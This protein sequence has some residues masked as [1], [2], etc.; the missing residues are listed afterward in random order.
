M[1]TKIVASAEPPYTTRTFTG[2][3]INAFTSPQSRAMVGCMDVANKPLINP[4]VG[5]VEVTSWSLPIEKFI[6]TSIYG[7]HGPAFEA[8]T[9][10]GESTHQPKP[11]KWRCA[12]MV[13]WNC[14]HVTS[15]PEP[16]RPAHRGP[17]CHQNLQGQGVLLH[18]TRPASTIAGTHHHPTTVSVCVS[19]RT[20][21]LQAESHL[22]S[23]PLQQRNGCGDELLWSS[24]HQP[25]V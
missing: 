15:K 11:T 6:N 2:W 1:G 19:Y 4:M 3:L 17:R 9:P 16:C 12:S 13:G 10:L 7:K 25:L 21:P 5:F 14:R 18:P 24:P 8:T 23:G 22:G 20:V